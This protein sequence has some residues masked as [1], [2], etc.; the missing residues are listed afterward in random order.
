VSSR[1]TDAVVNDIAAW[2]SRPLE[3]V[4]PIVYLDALVVKVRDQGVV[5]NKSVYLALGVTVQ[6]GKGTARIWI[7]QTRAR[8]S[9]PK[10]S[11]GALLVSAAWCAHLDAHSDVDDRLR[12]DLIELL[13]RATFAALP[14]DRFGRSNAATSGRPPKAT[15]SRA[16]SAGW[17]PRARFRRA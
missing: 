14:H 3:T 12:E 17:F 16:G 4:Y 9:G 10:S 15:K 7:E 1:V 5:R 13:H 2:Q 11:D 8:N 6:G